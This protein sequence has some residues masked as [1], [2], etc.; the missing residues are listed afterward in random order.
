MEEHN[1][2]DWALFEK[3]WNYNV[4]AHLPRHDVISVSRQNAVKKISRNVKYV[5][6]D[7]NHEEEAYF[8]SEASELRLFWLGKLREFSYLD[9]QEYCEYGEGNGR[10]DLKKAIIL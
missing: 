2:A 4:D 10:K 5:E 8:F 6:N 3:P 7:Q 9:D 1:Q